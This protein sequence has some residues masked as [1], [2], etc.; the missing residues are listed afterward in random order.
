MASSRLGSLWVLLFVAL[1]TASQGQIAAAEFTLEGLENRPYRLQVF[2]PL[3]GTRTALDEGQVDMQGMV[4]MTWP[5]DGEVHFLELECAGIVWS[6]PVCG[7]YVQGAELAMPPQGGAPFSARQGAVLWTGATGR[8]W[9]PILVSEAQRILTEFEQAMAADLQQSLLWNG[10]GG[11]QKDHARGILGTPIEEGEAPDVKQDSLWSVYQTDFQR[12]FGA[13]LDRCS[14]G[15]ERDYVGSLQWR[16]L[17]ELYPDSARIWEREWT[18]CEL[19]APSDAAGVEHFLQGLGRVADFEGWSMEERQKLLMAL[20]DGDMDSLVATTSVWWG[21]TD[22]DRTTAWFLARF[23]DGGLGVEFPRRFE[24]T[25]PVP[26]GVRSLLEASADHP[27]FG[28]SSER[29]LKQC[30]APEALPGALRAFSASGNL[31]RMEEWAGAGPVAWLWLDASAPT[32]VL[33]LQVLERM[34]TSSVGQGRRSNAPFRDLKWMVVDAGQ[35]WAAFEQLIRDA[36]ARHGGLRKLP[37]GMLHT[38]GDIRW[39]EAFEI[40]TLPAVRHS[41]PGLVP[42]PEVPPMPGP[43]LIDWLA[44]R[45]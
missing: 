1:S 7:P 30:A 42:T 43:A 15:A 21:G 14:K 24:D 2:H 20:L 17:P 40:Q 9:T 23:G 44:K 22:V 27:E 29:L 4:R 3:T 12:A 8:E 37:Y 19:P 16:I 36:A 38:G 10:S 11:P 25:L 39:T 32:T 5:D 26:E 18:E 31:M 35:D 33:Q 34:M 45:S 41:G 6:L 13:L 28:V